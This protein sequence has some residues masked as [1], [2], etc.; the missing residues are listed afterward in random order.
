MELEQEDKWKKEK[1]EEHEFIE[2]QIGRLRKQMQESTAHR[3]TLALQR[4]L[5]TSRKQSGDL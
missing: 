5:D 1:E 4:Q 2:S 3:E